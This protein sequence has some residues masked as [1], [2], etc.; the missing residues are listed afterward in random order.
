MANDTFDTLVVGA[1]ILGLAV[2]R[3]ILLRRPG[4][5][6][7]VVER[8]SRLAAHQTGHNSGVIHAGVYYAPGS[9]KAELCVDG[10]ARMYAYCESHDVAVKRIG[11]LI[12]ALQPNE[13][14]AL[15]EIERRATANGVSGIRRVNADELRHIEPHATGLAALHSPNT[16]IVDFGAVCARLADDV[17]KAGGEVRLNWSVAG[18]RDAGRAIRLR[19]GTGDEVA[20]TRSVFCAGLWSDRL[21]ELA[22]ADPDPR[23]IPFRGRY[24]A[25]RPERRDLVRGLIYPVPD[26]RLPFLGI[27]LTPRI[28]GQVLLGPSAM[29]VGARD[30]YQLAKIRDEDV[31]AT[32]TWPGTW[33]MAQRWWRTGVSE[34]RL[35]TSRRAFASEASRF[36]PELVADDLLP[37]LS[38]VRA[39]AVGRDGHLVDDFL[40]STTPRAIHVRNAPSPAATSSLALAVRIADAADALG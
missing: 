17:H 16:G 3:E 9:L 10:A 4:E 33:R 37:S 11:K 8:E 18:V 12:I 14:P 24:L 29:L 22:G 31:R 40:L 35:A 34:L 7:L 30:A 6:V 19:S 20:G 36:V 39:Q 28:D 5:R 1:G 38:G 21:A 27:H 2:A 15:E 25:L 26:P 13:M 32:V 23:I